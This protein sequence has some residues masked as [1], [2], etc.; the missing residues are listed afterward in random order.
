M[1][2]LKRRARPD[3]QLGRAHVLSGQPRGF[4]HKAILFTTIVDGH[5]VR[6]IH[7]SGRFDGDDYLLAEHLRHLA[8][9]HDAHL[10]TTTESQ[11][12]RVRKVVRKAFGKR[13]GIRKRGEYLCIF[14]RDT[15]RNLKRPRLDVI[16]QIPNWARWRQMHVAT[17]NLRHKPSKR[18]LRL[19]VIHGPSGIQAGSRFRVG[20][21]AQIAWQGWAKVGR[22]MRRFHRTHRNAWQEV[23][24]DCNGNLRDPFWMGWFEAQTGATCIWR[25]QV[26]NTGTHA[27]GRLI[28]AAWIYDAEPRKAA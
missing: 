12:K 21:Q 2:R 16:T 13:W 3:I 1:P 10:I 28:D 4:D 15:F 11:Q 22:K 14:R 18:R 25:N 5:K 27:G 6:R 24:A 7:W 26:P 17:F 19:L 20:K 9:K 23:A 8:D